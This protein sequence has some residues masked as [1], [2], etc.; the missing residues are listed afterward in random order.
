ML[1][2]TA[3]AL[4]LLIPL[5]LAAWLSVGWAAQAEQLTSSST[6]STQLDGALD[7]ILQTAAPMTEPSATDVPWPYAT[8]DESGRIRVIVKAAQ[9]EKV[10]DLRSSIA[11]AGGEVQ[12]TVGSKIQATFPSRDAVAELSQRADVARVR[13]PVRP[14][15]RQG[16]IVSEGV[17][18]SQAQAWQEDGVDGSGVKVGVLDA[19]FKGYEGL[20]GSELPPEQRVTARSFR[21]DGDLACADCSDAGQVHGRAVAEIIHDIAPGAELYLANFN[22]GVEMES[23]VN[24][25]IDNGVDVINTSFGFLTTSCPYEGEGILDSIFKRARENGIVW[26]A[27]SG[28]GGQSHWAGSFRDPDEDGF[29]RF[30]EEDES[31]T[32]RGVEEGD[33]IVALMWWDDACS[34]AE[35][36]YDMVLRQGEEEIERSFRG[37]PTDGWPLEIISVEAPESGTYQLKV[38]GVE[39]GDNELSLLVFSQ[40][41]EHVVPAGSAGLSEP[42]MSSHVVSV[43]ATDLENQLEPF[44]SRGPT[45]D[46][47]IKPEIVAPNGVS[48]R[49]FRPFFGTS[50]SSPHVAGAAAL[51]N[52]AFP[53]FSPQEIEDFLTKR[54]E[55]LGKPGEDGKFGAGLLTL[56]QAPEE[57]APT[58]PSGL[59]AS[60]AGPSEINLRWQDNAERENGFVLF[61]QIQ[62]ETKFAEIARLDADT[63]TY[64]DGDLSPATTYCYVVRAFN[65]TGRSAASK[66]ICAT[67]AEAPNSSPTADAGPDRTV[68]VGDTVQLDG[69]GSSD[70]EGAALSY[71]W[72]LTDRPQSSTAEIQRATTAQPSLQPDLPGTYVVRLTVTDPDGASATDTVQIQAQERSRGLV[73]L[74]FEELS[75]RPA[76]AWNRTVKDGCVHY[77]NVSDAAATVEVKLPDDR[78]VEFE[79]PAGRDVVVCGDVIHIDTRPSAEP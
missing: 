42:E 18:I 77:R 35:H 47:R 12:L 64:T 54:A 15:L 10:G 31:Q 74:V 49:T 33:G 66:T 57:R 34:G 36:D 46:G 72:T 1:R 41:P 73:A 43:G 71:E 53:K 51:V 58:A 14:T 23:A 50:A 24:W 63:T 70:P 62:D 13:A 30:H 8:D 27:S 22:T 6:P 28:N 40:E 38:K 61:R 26:V 5:V 3:R 4:A 55:D 75:F 52:S 11:D 76:T 39:P 37:G 56:G 60:A 25:M 68:A 7:S 17:D 67:T 19:G 59:N 2:L 32:L 69:S 16:A 45:P 9:A 48:N 65:D 44:S 29:T 20:L 21:S 78:V 79:V